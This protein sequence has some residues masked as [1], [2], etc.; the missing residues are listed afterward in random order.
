[1]R[2]LY[3][4]NVMRMGDTYS[5]NYSSKVKVYRGSE[6]GLKT[7]LRKLG[8]TDNES[9]PKSFRGKTFDQIT[10]EIVNQS[11]PFVYIWSN[12]LDKMQMIVTESLQEKTPKWTIRLGAEVSFDYMRKVSVF[13]NDKEYVYEIDNFTWYDAKELFNK[14]QYYKFVN[15]MKPFFNKGRKIK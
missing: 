13:I 11:D 10:Q 12:K 5:F 15:K 6:K 9:E 8:A 3:R 4:V 7:L 2:K 1:M 14:G